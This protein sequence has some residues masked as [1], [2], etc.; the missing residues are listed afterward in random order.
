MGW[1]ATRDSSGHR[2]C[3]RAVVRISN[4]CSGTGCWPALGDRQRLRPSGP[5]LHPKPRQYSGL[6]QLGQV[7]KQ[8]NLIITCSPWRDSLY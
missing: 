2:L 3:L 6:Q 1:D 8:T 4:H 7:S 5:P